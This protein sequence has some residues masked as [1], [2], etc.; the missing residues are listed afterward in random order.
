[1]N[2]E[3]TPKARY[4]IAY[5]INAVS[6]I[7]K[8]IHAPN[9][10]SAVEI[11]GKYHNCL[12][13]SPAK[14]PITT[15]YIGFTAKN[16]MKHIA[17]PLYPFAKVTAIHGN[18]SIIAPDKTSQN[19]IFFLIVSFSSKKCLRQSSLYLKKYF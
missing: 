17:I 18:N 16:K 19:I 3:R 11:T 10:N 15:E 14:E 1:M 9:K 5:E 13:F 6:P 4:I 7:S 8:K 12:L 2:M